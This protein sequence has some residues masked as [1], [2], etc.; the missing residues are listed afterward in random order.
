MHYYNLDLYSSYNRSSTFFISLF[1]RYHLSLYLC[2]YVI[3]LM[4]RPTKA[5]SNRNDSIEHFVL[6]KYSESEI[7]Q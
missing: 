7:G 4:S 1:C 6:L 5:I 2:S 3:N